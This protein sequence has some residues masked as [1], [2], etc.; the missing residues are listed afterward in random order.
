MIDSNSNNICVVRVKF[1]VEC[2]VGGYGVLAIAC[3]VDR[4]VHNRR[5][6]REQFKTQKSKHTIVSYGLSLL[7]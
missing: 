5:H 2:Y 7:K 6:S 3:A 4:A 1:V